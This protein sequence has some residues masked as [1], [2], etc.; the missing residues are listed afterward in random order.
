LRALRREGTGEETGGEIWD[1]LG[2]SNAVSDEAMMWFRAAELKHGRAAMV[3]P[4]P[5]KLS[6]VAS[7]A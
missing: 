5:V 2:I 4:H 1:P 7:Q 6:R 3:R